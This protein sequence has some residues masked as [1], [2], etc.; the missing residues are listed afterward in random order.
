MATTAGSGT[1]V[2][3]GRGRGGAQPCWPPEGVVRPGTGL[4]RRVHGCSARMSRTSGRRSQQGTGADVGAGGAR[5]LS[6]ARA[7]TSGRAALGRSRARRGSW[8]RPRRSSGEKG[9]R[10]SVAQQRARQGAGA[11]RRLGSAR[12]ARLAGA[13]C[14]RERTG[15]AAWLAQALP[16]SW[17]VSA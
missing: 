15:P 6:R 9:G 1:G 5:S 13:T 12:V 8:R 10:H 17:C 14:R 7:R 16:A 3:S 11:V 4:W 2:G